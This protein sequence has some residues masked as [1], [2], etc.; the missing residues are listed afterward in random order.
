[1]PSIRLKVPALCRNSRFACYAESNAGIFRLALGGGPR[2]CQ[3]AGRRSGGLVGRRAGA[4]G[5]GGG[6]RPAAVH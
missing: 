5:G 4:G 2:G 6:L 1:M 3:L